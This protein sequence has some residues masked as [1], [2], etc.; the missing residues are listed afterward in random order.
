MY[1]TMYMLPV[2][3]KDYTDASADVYIICTILPNHPGMAENIRE[4]LLQFFLQTNYMK[5]VK[6]YKRRK[7]CGGGGGDDGG[8]FS[9]SFS[10]CGEKRVKK[11]VILCSDACMAR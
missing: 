3:S 1:A 9:F 7:R 8:F 11:K 6:K 4:I 2:A 10:Q 5:A